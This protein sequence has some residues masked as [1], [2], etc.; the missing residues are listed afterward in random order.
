MAPLLYPARLQMSRVQ[1]WFRSS[2]PSRSAWIRCRSRGCSRLLAATALLA[3]CLLA[4]PFLAPAFFLRA[5][6]LLAGSGLLL[7]RCLATGLLG[8]GLLLRS[9]GLLLA[10]AAFFF[11]PG[12][13]PAFFAA[14]FAAFFLPAARIASA[15]ARGSSVV[16]SSLLTVELLLVSLFVVTRFT[17]GR[18][19]SRFRT[20]SAAIIECCEQTSVIGAAI[21]RGTLVSTRASAARVRKRDG[22]TQRMRRRRIRR[23]CDSARC[24]CSIDRASL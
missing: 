15:C 6:L 9:G 7:R 4:A 12:L 8:G 22:P 19:G 20:V 10:T 1:R 14:F 24:R 13:R 16:V 5:G 11:G 18:P 21:L 3:A 23:F 17:E 2:S